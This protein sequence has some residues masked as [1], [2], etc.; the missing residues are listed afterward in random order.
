MTGVNTGLLTNVYPLSVEQ[1]KDLENK[2]INNKQAFVYLNEKSE[3]C[4]AGP[5]GIA[6][7][8]KELAWNRANELVTEEGTFIKKIYKKQSLN[9]FFLEKTLS[10]PSLEDSW[11]DTLVTG[12]TFKLVDGNTFITKDNL[13]FEVKEY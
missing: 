8:I 6:E 5:A 2:V 7:L 4:F 13:I 9:T 10:K 12:Y 3:L 1:I 11:T